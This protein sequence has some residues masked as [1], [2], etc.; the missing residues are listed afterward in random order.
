[1]KK[2]TTTYYMCGVNWQEEMEHKP[3][4]YSTLKALKKDN[5]CWGQCGIVKVEMT[6]TWIEP[7]DFSK[8]I[9]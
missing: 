9:E 7:Q 8:E 3:N 5:K 6:A 2:K 4:M 1:M